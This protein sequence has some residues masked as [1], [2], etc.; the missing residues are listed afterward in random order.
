MKRY[1]FFTLL[2]LTISL[3]INAQKQKVTVDNDTIKVDGTP[4]GIIEKKSALKS[5]YTIKSLDGKE[6]IFLSGQEFDDPTKINSG[7]PKGTVRYFEVTFLNS[8]RKCEVEIASTKKGVAKIVVENH[9]LKGNEVDSDAEKKFI[10]VNG[11][12]F[13]ERK[14]QLAAPKVI[15]IEK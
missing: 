4:Y 13:T 3:T 6:Q 10:V 12:K 5:D 11:T 1:S 7:N 2:L 15:I 8:G 14:N 9:L